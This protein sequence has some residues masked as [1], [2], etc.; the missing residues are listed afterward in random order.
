[1]WPGAEAVLYKPCF[2]SR[3]R[4]LALL[5]WSQIKVDLRDLWGLHPPVEFDIRFPE[6]KHAY[7]SVKKVLSLILLKV[8]LA[9][10]IIEM[11]LLNLTVADKLNHQQLL[12]KASAALLNQNVIILCE[13]WRID[14]MKW[15]MLPDEMWSQICD[16]PTKKIKA[17]FCQTLASERAILPLFF[18]T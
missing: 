6:W 17:T 10:C 5:L 13:T 12:W 7:R 8:I 3:F 11:W 9:A 14:E 4:A 1:M 2:I 18:K 16:F 15:C